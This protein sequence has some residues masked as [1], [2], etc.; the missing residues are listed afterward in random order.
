M[1][2]RAIPFDRGEGG[3]EGGEEGVGGGRIFSSPP[4]LFFFPLP[5]VLSFVI[6]V[7]QF[8]IKRE[9]IVIPVEQWVVVVVVEDS[10]EKNSSSRAIL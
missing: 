10:G 2:M 1:M 6:N 8:L 5:H 4:P 9:C 3:R 7:M